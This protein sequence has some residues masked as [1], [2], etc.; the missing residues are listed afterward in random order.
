MVTWPL[1]QRNKVEDS[2]INEPVEACAESDV[3]AL[4]EIAKKVREVYTMLG[5]THLSF[6]CSSSGRRWS[7]HIEYPSA[8]AR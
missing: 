8:Y 3:P 5:R 2:K 4:A 6:S 7:M 1:I